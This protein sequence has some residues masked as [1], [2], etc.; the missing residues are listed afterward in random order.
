M[1]TKEL[2]KAI[3][4][5]ITALDEAMKE[6]VSAAKSALSDSV[7]ANAA[8]RRDVSE[9]RRTVEG[10]IADLD[11]QAAALQEQKKKIM[12]QLARK[13]VT[14]G[15]KAVGEA[16]KELSGIVA[17]LAVISD[18]KTALKRGHVP[19][20]DE[21]Y[22]NAEEAQ[23][24]LAEINTAKSDA[25]GLVQNGIDKLT[26]KLEEVHEYASIHRGSVYDNFT[27]VK[28]H[29]EGREDQPQEEVTPTAPVRN[30]HEGAY[31][32]PPSTRY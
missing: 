9:K 25:F 12:D 20:S 30:L 2:L 5:G 22:V 1:E 26:K 14:T 24:K 17:D 16:Q 23:N 21:L 18:M 13:A 31:F 4:D 15:S 6:V 8:Y 3:E 10:Q 28:D 11:N 32:V 27:A 29:Y 19:G 7:E